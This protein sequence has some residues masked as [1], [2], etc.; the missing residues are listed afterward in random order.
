[1]N[2]YPNKRIEMAESKEKPQD[3][4]EID[5]LNSGLPPNK[6]LSVGDRFSVAAPELAMAGQVEENEGLKDGMAKKFP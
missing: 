3:T 5:G 6:L 2:T 1:M 4:M